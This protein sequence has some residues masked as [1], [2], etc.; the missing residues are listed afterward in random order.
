MIDGKP[1][2]K[3]GYQRLLSSSEFSELTGGRTIEKD[4]AIK[5]LL[6]ALWGPRCPSSASTPGPSWSWRRPS[7]SR[8]GARPERPGGVRVSCRGWIRR[9]GGAGGRRVSSRTRRRSCRPSA[10]PAVLRGMRWPARRQHGGRGGRGHHRRCCLV[11]LARLAPPGDAGSLLGKGRG[12]RPS[13]DHLGEGPGC[14]H[15]VPLPLEARVLFHGLAPPEPSVEGRQGNAA[16]DMDAAQL[17]Q[18]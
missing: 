15:P 14:A 11:L 18:G 10:S 17:R 12:L 1:V 6:Q 2:D 13:A 16:I 5:H 4:L 3:S 9:A 7:I 8:G